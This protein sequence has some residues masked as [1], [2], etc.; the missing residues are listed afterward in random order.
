[1]FR[2]DHSS[3]S[4]KLHRG[5]AKGVWMGSRLANLCKYAYVVV[6]TRELKAGRDYSYISCELDEATEPRHLLQLTV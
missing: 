3:K 5:I 6:T 4:E 2:L 1:L